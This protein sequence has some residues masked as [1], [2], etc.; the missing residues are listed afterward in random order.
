MEN[1]E[2]IEKKLNSMKNGENKYQFDVNDTHENDAEEE[3]EA[4]KKKKPWENEDEQEGKKDQDDPGAEENDESKKK[5]KGK[6]GDDDDDDT[7]VIATTADGS[8]INADLR[9][10]ESFFEVAIKQYSSNEKLNKALLSRTKENIKLVRAEMR[11][12]ENR[13]EVNDKIH[14]VCKEMEAIV[15]DEARRSKYSDNGMAKAL[16][17][18]FEPYTELSY[19]LLAMTPTHAAD[20]QFSIETRDLFAD[21]S[22]MLQR[23]STARTA[24]ERILLLMTLGSQYR[25]LFQSHSMISGEVNFVN[26]RGTAAWNQQTFEDLWA[27]YLYDVEFNDLV[28]VDGHPQTQ[29]TTRIDNIEDNGRKWRGQVGDNVQQPDV[30][31]VKPFFLLFVDDKLIYELRKLHISEKALSVLGNYAIPTELWGESASDTWEPEHETYLKSAIHCKS[32]DG[33]QAY[34]DAVKNDFSKVKFA[35][36]RPNFEWSHNGTLNLISNTPAK[37]AA[38][39]T[40]FIN[41]VKAVIQLA[42]SVSIVEISEDLAFFMVLTNWLNA[43]YKY[44]IDING[45]FLQYVEKGVKAN[46]ER[47][48]APFTQD[49]ILKTLASFTPQEGTFEASSVYDLLIRK[50][51]LEYDRSTSVGYTYSPIAY[52]YMKDEFSS[53]TYMVNGDDEFHIGKV[54]VGN[55]KILITLLQKLYLPINLM[56]TDNDLSALEIK[57]NFMSSTFGHREIKVA[58]PYLFATS[59]ISL[60]FNKRRGASETGL[61]TNVSLFHLMMKISCSDWNKII[62]DFLSNQVY[63]YDGRRTTLA[64]IFNMQPNAS[65]SANFNKVPHIRVFNPMTPAYK[66]ATY[67]QLAPLSTTSPKVE[68]DDYNNDEI[69]FQPLMD[70]GFNA[71]PSVFA[72]YTGANNDYFPCSIGWMIQALINE[73]ADFSWILQSIFLTYIRTKLTFKICEDNNLKTY[74]ND[75]TLPMLPFCIKLT[76]GTTVVEVKSANYDT[77]TTNYPAVPYST[78]ARRRQS[79]LKKLGYN[80][81]YINS[82]IEPITISSPKTALSTN[83]IIKA[84]RFVPYATN[85]YNPVTHLTNSV[86]Y[87]IDNKFADAGKSCAKTIYYSVGDPDNAGYSRIQEYRRIIRDGEAINITESEI[88]QQVVNPDFLNEGF[89]IFDDYHVNNNTAATGT[90]PQYNQTTVTTPFAHA[91][92]AICNT[93]LVGYRVSNIANVFPHMARQDLYPLTDNNL[94]R[95]CY[96]PDDFYPCCILFNNVIPF[97]TQRSVHALGDNYDKRNSFN[98]LTAYDLIANVFHRVG[99]DKYDFASTHSMLAALVGLDPAMEIWELGNVVRDADEYCEIADGSVA[100]RRAA[101]GCGFYARRTADG[102]AKSVKSDINADIRDN[103]GIIIKC[104]VLDPREL[105]KLMP[106]Q[107]QSFRSSLRYPKMFVAPASVELSGL[108]IYKGSRDE[109]EYYINSRKAISFFKHFNSIVPDQWTELYASPETDN[110][111]FYNIQLQGNPNYSGTHNNQLTTSFTIKEI[112]SSLGIFF[113]IR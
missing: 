88:R 34:G 107:I 10:S 70:Q 48:I 94:N 110:I 85:E 60:T 45:S 75:F 6:K 27:Y 91:P 39:N 5:P 68:N 46:A 24:S 100:D 56:I 20:D 30:T 22:E 99:F 102:T 36:K 67:L 93:N 49:V 55:N 63:T 66:R 80:P 84:F 81:E 79:F 62:D 29:D 26:G 35:A 61:L 73:H 59:V 76:A 58:N 54:S 77:Y 86:N 52:N 65:T 64:N 43:V 103:V 44:M 57:T 95:Y 109:N 42:E 37:L 11:K 14:D 101:L 2:Q 16:A 12:A 51:N 41:E 38:R 53:V 69:W 104:G 111:A 96:I 18:A 25:T 71:A 13:N 32:N 8:S 87:I 105:M 74:G 98:N 97:A 1:K 31:I 92:Y 40:A 90:E 3:A 112:L 78:Y 7:V 108:P 89:I 15:N 83:D 21:I 28:P 50:V 33:Y 19:A 47:F 9:K 113:N 106:G 23:I 17:L 82:P 4:G 72:D